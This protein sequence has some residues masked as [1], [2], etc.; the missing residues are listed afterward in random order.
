MP[1]LSPLVNDCD[2][3]SSVQNRSVIMIVSNTL[4][5]SD[6]WRKIPWKSCSR[7]TSAW[8]A[9]VKSLPSS[10]L[11]SQILKVRGAR[12]LSVMPSARS[13]SC[14]SFI[15]SSYRRDQPKRNHTRLGQRDG[16]AALQ[17][18]RYTTVV[19]QP[20]G[21][22]SLMSEVVWDRGEL[23]GSQHNC[24]RQKKLL[25]TVRVKKSSKR[26]CKQGGFHQECPT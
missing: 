2:F 14:L 15:L 8:S 16:G 10:T 1:R 5:F 3:S 21:A 22:F 18:H 17:R 19:C 11:T 13:N 7:C 23:G 12:T 24:V 6:G 25:F 20:H 4:S 26:S 9:R